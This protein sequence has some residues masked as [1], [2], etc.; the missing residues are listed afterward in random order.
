MKA[1]EKLVTER[2]YLVPLKLE[3]LKAAIY[4]VG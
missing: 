4:S 1:L 3:F 2:L